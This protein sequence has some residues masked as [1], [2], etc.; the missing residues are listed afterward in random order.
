MWT[1]CMLLAATAAAPAQEGDLNLTNVRATYGLLGAPRPNDRLLPGDIFFVAFD[2]DG[3]K[4]DDSGKVLY[5]MAMEVTDS[6]NKTLFK[7]DPRE[8]EA[9]NALGGS[10]LP[11]F[12][13]VDVGLDQ[14]PGSYNLKV[15]VT[16][17]AAKKTQSFE[18]KF[19]V[20]DKGFGLVR[21]NIT[22]DPQGQVPV[23]AVGTAGQT[24]WVHLMAV[25]FARGGQ[26]NEPDISLEMQVLDENDRPV[27]GKPFPGDIKELPKELQAIPMDFQLP[28]NRAGRFNVRVK[29]I[30]KIAKKTA[31][32]S[33]PLQVVELK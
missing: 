18:R 8:L 29:A 5:S 22:G 1:M 25:G 15:T 19:E 6:K 28:L 16:D 2:I 24:M 17:R 27:L 3:I 23:S 9:L 31:E 33:F 11:A 10:H 12:A 20:M 7:Q 14:P 21:L 30:D 32:L 4:V 13:H 26:K